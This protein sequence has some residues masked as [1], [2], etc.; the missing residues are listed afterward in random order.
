MFF[1]KL[2]QINF[3][4]KFKLDKT[5]PERQR[6]SFYPR[7]LF[8]DQFQFFLFCFY[9]HLNLKF[10]HYKKPTSY[11]FGF[12]FLFLI[13]IKAKF[14]S[15]LPNLSFLFLPHSIKEVYIQIFIMKNSL[16]LFK[17]PIFITTKSNLIHQYT[18]HLFHSI[19]NLY[20]V[21]YN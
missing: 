8:W 9:F 13:P 4:K 11:T 12:L 21:H 2:A 14:N 16:N 17:D 5:L 3:F 18:F 6:E 7:F 20:F 19:I 15:I 10:A 1:L